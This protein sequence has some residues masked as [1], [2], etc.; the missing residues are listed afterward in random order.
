MIKRIALNKVSILYPLLKGIIIISE[1]VGSIIG[2][3]S[4]SLGLV[5]TISYISNHIFS[6][7]DHIATLIILLVISLALYETLGFNFD[8]LDY[9]DSFVASKKCKL[10]YAFNSFLS[11]TLLTSILNMIVFR[12]GITLIISLI[13]GIVIAGVTYNLEKLDKEVHN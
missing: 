8:F 12:N 11:A 9:C 1:I 13:F 4:V 3:F 7:A 10:L 6:G 2:L 5:N